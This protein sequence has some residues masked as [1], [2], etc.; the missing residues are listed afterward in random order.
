MANAV[1]KNGTF[2]QEQVDQIVLAAVVA[3]TGRLNGQPVHIH[4]CPDGHQWFCSSPYCEDVS[5]NPT[6]KCENHGGRPPILKGF[7][8]W[9]GGQR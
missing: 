5:A 2:T 3:A 1:V 4:R 6:L 8:P 7:E 9:R